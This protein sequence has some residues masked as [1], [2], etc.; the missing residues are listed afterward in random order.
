MTRRCIDLS[1]Q[2][3]VQL[4]FKVANYLIN[5][6]TLGKSELGDT[7]SQ[8][9]KYADGFLL[10][11]DNT[12]VKRLMGLKKSMAPKGCLNKTVL[13]QLAAAF[14]GKFWDLP[15]LKQNFTLESGS[16]KLRE[17]LGS[18]FDKWAGR[19]TIRHT[20]G[21]YIDTA[22]RT[23]PHKATEWMDNFSLG[24]ILGSKGINNN[25]KWTN[26]IIQQSYITYTQQYVSL[27]S[28]I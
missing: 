23:D 18:E 7:I 24:A 26:L 8:L 16:P 2:N 4:L 28:Y 9:L 17:D 1:A 14:G 20:E 25:S 27:L 15:G 5:P 21:L 22:I 6:G 13:E 11:R 10:P 19:E 12:M 3:A